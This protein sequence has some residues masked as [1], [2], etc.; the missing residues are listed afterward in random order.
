VRAG[1]GSVRVLSV[2]VTLPPD[3]R[4]GH[5]IQV[6]ADIDPGPLTPDDLMVQAYL[7]RVREGRELDLPASIAMSVE[8]VAGGKKLRYAVRVPCRASGTL[9]LTVRVLPRHADLGHPHETGL[10]TW[11]S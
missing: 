3:T 9:G 7:G 1:W 6:T 11:A 10:I 2:D 8:G 4:V 5:E